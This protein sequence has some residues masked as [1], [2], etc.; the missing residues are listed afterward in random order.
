MKPVPGDW[1]GPG[2]DR[3]LQR[4]GQQA[5]RDRPHR[6]RDV[7]QLRSVPVRTILPEILHATFHF[8]T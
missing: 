4:P 8:L 3:H 2:Q 5:A 7:H 1:C 6:P